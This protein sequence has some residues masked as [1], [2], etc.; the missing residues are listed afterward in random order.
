MSPF[1]T[2]NQKLRE[3]ILTISPGEYRT[4][5]IQAHVECMDPGFLAHHY[6]DPKSGMT[7]LLCDLNREKLLWNRPQKNGRERV[8][9]GIGIEKPQPQVTPAGKA[10]PQSPMIEDNDARFSR[11][12]AALAAVQIALAAQ[13]TILGRIEAMLPTKPAPQAAPQPLQTL[14]AVQRNG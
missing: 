5:Q 3:I 4:E 2:P 9:W 10:I 8:V 6:Q 12:E 13:G 1:K 11:T 14:A 7:S